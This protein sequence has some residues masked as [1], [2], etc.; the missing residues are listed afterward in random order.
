MKKL[1]LFTGIALALSATAALANG[2]NVTWGGNCWSD[3]GGTA[4][5]TFACNTNTGNATMCGSFLCDVAHPNFVGIEV[6]VDGQTSL[7]TVPDWWQLFNT[8]SCRPTSLSTS[9]DF[10]TAAA[11]GC[12]DPWLGLAQ[13][14]VAAWQTALFPPPFPLNAPAPNVVRLKVAYA[15]A[16]P[17]PL[18]AGVEYYGFKATVN[19][20][21]SAGTGACAGC[22]AGM[23]FALNQIK[24]AENTGPVEFCTVALPGGNQCLTWNGATTPCSAVP[25]KNTTWGQVKSLYR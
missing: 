8:G 25:A 9:A 21:K 5:K 10:T 11:I 17:S 16:N 24:A 6:V 4:V 2:V 20:L 18:S 13:G 22:S 7:S 19:Y 14:G 1:V 23:A 3:G 15:V 12:T